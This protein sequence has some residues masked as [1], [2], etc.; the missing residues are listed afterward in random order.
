MRYVEWNLEMAN[1]FTFA[2]DVAHTSVMGVS[3]WSMLRPYILDIPLSL[4][5]PQLGK[6]C[7]QKRRTLG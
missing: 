7:S 6:R 1:R 5:L 2:R 4:I 3:K